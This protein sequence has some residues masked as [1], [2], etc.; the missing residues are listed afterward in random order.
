MGVYAVESSGA[1]GVDHAYAADLAARELFPD[2]L[3]G[4]AHEFHELL[5]LIARDLAA[6]G[7]RGTDLW[8]LRRDGVPRSAIAYAAGALLTLDACAAHAALG[9]GVTR[10]R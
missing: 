7:R 2:Q 4:I 8:S 10:Q 1:I 3:I 9:V 5:A 6:V